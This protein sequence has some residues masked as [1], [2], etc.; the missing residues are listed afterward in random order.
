MFYTGIPPFCE[1]TDCDCPP[2]LSSSHLRPVH[3]HLPVIHTCPRVFLRNAPVRLQ[4][5]HQNNHLRAVCRPGPL[6]PRLRGQTKWVP[7]S[8]FG[9]IDT[10]CGSDEGVCLCL[11]QGTSWTSSWSEEN[12]DDSETPTTTAPSAT[13]NKDEGQQQGPSPTRSLES[14]HDDDEEER[15]NENELEHNTSQARDSHDDSNKAEEH[16]EWTSAWT[17]AWS[18]E[19][20]AHAESTD[21]QAT[22]APVVQTS[23]S[24]SNKEAFRTQE[25]N[26]R[27]T[28]ERGQRT[29][30]GATPTDSASNEADKSDLTSSGFI[31]AIS[32]RSS[33]HAPE[34]GTM[35]DFFE[36]NAA[37]ASAASA[38]ATSD[39]DSGGG[40][41]R[42]ATIGTIMGALA[43]VGVLV[44]I[45]FFIRRYLQAPDHGACQ[46]L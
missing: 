4:T 2:P 31:V 27:Q 45:V 16:Q 32:S 40:M 44:A 38:S 8:G 5:P 36:V 29:N 33:S 18:V 10:V 14:N 9:S 12:D 26:T 13:S 17:S 37:S 19:D 11:L 43:A 34:S 1:C 15:E 3:R 28:E 30:K 39:A 24:S 46:K 7:C 21:Q 25:R 22:D 35:S 41:S 23:S 20:T 42:A 6:L